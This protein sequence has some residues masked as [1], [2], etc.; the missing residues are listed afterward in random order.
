MRVLDAGLRHRFLERAH[1]RIDVVD[2]IVD[3]VDLPVSIQ[4]AQNDLAD[5]ARLEAAHFRLHRDTT[6]RGR[7]Q[8]RDVPDAQEGEVERAGDGGRRERQHVDGAPHQLQLLLVSDSEPLLLIDH[9]EAEVSERDVV[10]QQAVSADENVELSFRRRARDLFLLRGAAES[11]D[12]FDV[13]WELGHAL[14]ESPE[15]LLRED[16]RGH[17]HGDLFS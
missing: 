3:V 16:G 1:H 7:R 6:L 13:H 8:A 15:V 17:E 9:D 11:A 2:P 12:D 5:A 10:R 4:L 14:A